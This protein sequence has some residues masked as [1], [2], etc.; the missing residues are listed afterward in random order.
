MEESVTFSALGGCDDLDDTA[1]L[2]AG[3]NMFIVLEERYKA[4]IFI[5]TQP[6]FV[7]VFSQ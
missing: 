2:T 4:N 7:H 1:G 5:N 6:H 3:L